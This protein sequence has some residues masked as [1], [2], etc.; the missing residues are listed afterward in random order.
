LVED[1]A[2]IESLLQKY[3]VR[4]IGL[5]NPTPQSVARLNKSLNIEWLLDITAQFP[6]KE[7]LQR[8]SSNLHSWLHE[9]E[10]EDDRDQIELWAKQVS[11]GKITEEDFGEKLRG[12]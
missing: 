8:L 4:K 12:M 10:D 9:V 3:S 2:S 6:Q 7:N 5:E 11:K 1:S